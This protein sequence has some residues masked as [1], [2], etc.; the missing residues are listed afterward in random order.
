MNAPSNSAL[1]K[2]RNSNF[3]LSTQILRQWSAPGIILAITN[4]ADEEVLLSHAVH[5]ARRSTARVLLLHVLEPESLPPHTGEGTPPSAQQSLAESALATLNRMARQLRWVGVPCEPLLLRGSPAQEILLVAKARGVDRLLVTTAC[6][7]RTRSTAPRTLAEDLLSGALVPLCSVGEC[8]P[9]TP[10]FGQP[11]GEIT[12]ALSL[13]SEAALPLAFAARLAQENGAKLTVMH[14]FGNERKRRREIERT[15][16][17][18]ASQLPADM[19]REAGLLCPLEIA[20][21]KGDPVME[22]LKYGS[23]SNEDF[24]VLGPVSETQPLRAWTSN[25]VQRVISEAHCPVIV[26]GPSLGILN[27]G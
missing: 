10:V 6:A 8:L 9:P 21:R 24:I 5:Q 22:I 11:A 2:T 13:D 1:E 7:R 16:L 15:P 20:I 25:I 12:L 4:L 3:S 17:A 23:R 27:N 19:L 14:V 26:L 18:V